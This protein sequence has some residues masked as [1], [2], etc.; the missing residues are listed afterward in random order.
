MTVMWILSRHAL[1]GRS[2]NVAASE[3]F[4]AFL[5][6]DADDR[7]GRSVGQHTAVLT[8][9]HTFSHVSWKPVGHRKRWKEKLFPELHFHDLVNYCA[10]N[11][12]GAP[13]G[14]RSPELATPLFAAERVGSLLV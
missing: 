5:H 10:R 13:Y 3:P 1:Q 8:L 11:G 4:H 14:R 2:R 9:V 6:T 12:G 7:H